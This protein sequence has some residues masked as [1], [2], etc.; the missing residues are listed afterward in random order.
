[1]GLLV[2]G[3]SWMKP[4]RTT[5]RNTLRGRDGEALSRAVFVE[6]GADGRDKTCSRE[7]QCLIHELLLLCKVKAGA[8]RSQAAFS[9]FLV[10]LLRGLDCLRRVL[11]LKSNR[12]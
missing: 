1:M 5:V 3:S 11:R 9:R 6:G 8:L 2:S 7:V 4:W 10:H 12:T